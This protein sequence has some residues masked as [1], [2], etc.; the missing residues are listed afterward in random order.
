MTPA[1]L[2]GALAHMICHAFM[3]ICCFFCAGAVIHKSGKTLV[4]ELKGLGMA[5]PKTFIVFTISGL[6]LM[7]VPGLAGFVSKWN[8]AKGAVGA[9]S[10][11]GYLGLG[12]LLVSALLTAIYMMSI[13]VSAFFPGRDF[14]YAPLKGIK[15]PGWKMM[16]PLVCFVCVIFVLGLK[17]AVLSGFLTS[18]VS[19]VF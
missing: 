7:G 9:G 17:P 12:A 2:T 1:S 5:M 3:K 13:A 6:A 15:D 16:L 19:G 14:D 18:V 8:I 11:L 10:V 4:P